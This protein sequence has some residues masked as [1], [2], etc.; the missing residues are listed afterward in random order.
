MNRIRLLIV[1]LFATTTL[2]NAQVSVST[3]Q[4]DGTE[5]KLVSVNKTEFMD[6]DDTSYFKFTMSSY[7]D[8]CYYARIDMDRVLRS[9]Y[10]VS[11]VEPSYTCFDESQV[12][13]NANGKYI[14]WRN[15]TSHEIDYFTIMSFNG[16]E[17]KLFHKAKENTIPGM[18]AYITL[19]RVRQDE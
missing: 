14:V 15:N 7:I 2:C 3:C 12:G 4:L 17:M 8:S 16:D 19:R 9:T 11:N 10:Y 6:D 5:W 13:V 1:A 18:N